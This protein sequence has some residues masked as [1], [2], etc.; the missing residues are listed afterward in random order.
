MGKQTFQ[1]RGGPGPDA[2]RH[3]KGVLCV[4]LC[5]APRLWV[6]LCWEFYQHPHSPPSSETM[7]AS[8]SSPVGTWHTV[9]LCPLQGF[10][11]ET[12]I[13]NNNSFALSVSGAELS[14]H[15]HRK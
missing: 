9:R 5:A 3:W 1:L 10:I 11:L 14:S 6:L 8:H 15:L 4:R 2:T 13:N 7:T 12:F